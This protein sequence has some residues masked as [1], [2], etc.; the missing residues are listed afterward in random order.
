[1][2]LHKNN[3]SVKNKLDI[4]IKKINYNLLKNKKSSFIT[5][6]D[7]NVPLN[8]NNNGSK[9][10]SKHVSPRQTEKTTICLSKDNEKKDNRNDM[11]NLTKNFS[12]QIITYN[13]LN[14]CKDFVSTKKTKGN[15]NKNKSKINYNKGHSPNTSTN[16]DLLKSCNNFKSN[17]LQS[18]S[19]KHLLINKSK[20]KNVNNNSNNNISS[21]LCKNSHSKSPS[22][23]VSPESNHHS[24][25]T[26][27][28]HLQLN[29]KINKKEN[30]TA[31]PTT[32]NS[33]KDSKEKQ[34][35]KKK[36]YFYYSNKLIKSY[37]EKHVNANN[38]KKSNI[39]NNNSN[40]NINIAQS[41]ITV[42]KNSGFVH[43]KTLKQKLKKVN[44]NITPNMNYNHQIYNTNKNLS[45]IASMKSLLT[46]NCNFLKF[47]HNYIYSKNS[48][49]NSNINQH[50]KNNCNYNNSTKNTSLSNKS[51][52][53]KEEI[54]HNYN[55]N[56]DYLKH[57][58]N[59]NKFH[60][61]S[62]TTVPSKLNSKSTSRVEEQQSLI[63]MN[64]KERVI[65]LCKD[66]LFAKT[67]AHSPKD[68]I[69]C[70]IVY[71]HQTN[72]QKLNK[73]GKYY[74]NTNTN[75][76]KKTIQKLSKK[77][78]NESKYTNN[79]DINK[80][81]FENRVNTDNI[82]ISNNILN[83]N[84]IKQL[85]TENLT[86]E[87]ILS[88]ENTY[89]V[90]NT[91]S[92]IHSVNKDLY[93][94]RKERDK[95]ANYIQQYYETEG[96][97]P[98]SKIHFYKYG[99]VIG[100]GAFGK[101]NIALHICSGQLV[102]IKS[103]NKKNL[104]NQKARKKIDQEI[105]IMKKAQSQ[106][107]AQI[108]D[109]FENDT[110]I[111]IVME[112]ICEDLLNYISK[113]SQIPEI[114]AKV[115]FKQ[116]IEG[117]QF[118][119]SK[120]IVHRDIKLDN[121]LIDLS[122]TVKLCDFGVSRIVKLN[123][124]MYDH[125]GTPAY[126]APEIFLNKGY[127]GFA[128]DIWSAGVTLHYMLSGNQPFKGS[129]LSKLHKNILEEQLTTIEGISNDANHLIQRMLVRNPKN[130]ITV[131]EILYHPWLSGINTNIREN[132]KINYINLYYLFN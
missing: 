6:F 36:Y 32:Q 27:L 108:L 118:L 13:N 75:Y 20:G 117:I 28:S 88:E 105:G 63:I 90:I 52:K 45:D 114:T 14:F 41:K 38:N 130:R 65:T 19:N 17:F 57:K 73:P 85:E 15:V 107:V 92:S 100:R 125:C 69:K 132:S 116:I 35:I 47:K 67:A 110:H 115:I 93:F 2:F 24:V 40:V 111:F 83:E 96:H 68:L 101:V 51:V 81:S 102:A 82:L 61:N 48:S 77:T 23:F 26:S 129:N 58:I 30:H 3:N 46:N 5:L 12:S 113:R 131:E 21:I 98:S 121:I 112:Y 106:F 122:N 84:E 70:K 31:N 66:K 78:E 104:K 59:I 71:V 103:F 128:C 8:E 127:K 76:K 99:K 16:N 124:I 89:Q 74:F 72:K 97:Y 53:R 54:E 29:M 18:K 1:M 55:S 44:K 34:K 86:I 22:V 43:N 62:L 39:N 50:L 109:Y 95:V 7:D 80:H 25:N 10:Q 119:H 79:K 64:S 60:K 33:K 91:L 120:N 87:K 123:D 56:K 126:I 9:S 49:N 4:S 94:Y 11:S 37:D 42:N